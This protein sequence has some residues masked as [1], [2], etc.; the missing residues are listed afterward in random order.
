MI[1]SHLTPSSNTQT[2]F[3]NRSNNQIVPRVPPIAA[4]TTLTERLA[5]LRSRR[6][7]L[8]K[9][10]SIVFRPGEYLGR[11]I[12]LAPTESMIRCRHSAAIRD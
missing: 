8:A 4:L 1:L 5:A 12:S 10:C 3:S 9:S 11:K 7:S 6:F 2:T